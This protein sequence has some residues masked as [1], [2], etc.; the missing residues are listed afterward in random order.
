[1]THSDRDSFEPERAVSAFLISVS[2]VSRLAQRG[3]RYSTQWL[4]SARD[5]AD[6][7]AVAGV[8]RRL[9]CAGQM[10]VVRSALMQNRHAI[11]IS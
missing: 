6:F 1:M 10:R 3:G 7:P 2:I 11:R 4:P 5:S 8:A 9:V